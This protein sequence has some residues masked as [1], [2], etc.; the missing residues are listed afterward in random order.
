ML[1][2]LCKICGERHHRYE[3]HKF[4][5]AGQDAVW[6]PERRKPQAAK[7]VEAAVDR[8]RPASGGGGKV[9]KLEIAVLVPDREAFKVMDERVFGEICKVVE[10][11]RKR[12]YRL[13]K[14]ACKQRQSE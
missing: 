8:G 7:P 1:P 6:A 4:R 9:D 5:D 11:E 12:R 10:A 14:K 3:P 2:Q 13:T